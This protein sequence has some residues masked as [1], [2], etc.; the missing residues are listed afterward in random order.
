MNLDELM[1]CLRIKEDNRK[2]ERRS[3]VQFGVNFIEIGLK[4]VNKKCKIFDDNSKK[5]KKFKCNFYNCE[6]VEHRSN[7]CRK[8][9]KKAHANVVKRDTLSERIQEMNMSAVVF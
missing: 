5:A 3:I 6:K 8:P 2:I 4:F 7:E 1:V 9:K